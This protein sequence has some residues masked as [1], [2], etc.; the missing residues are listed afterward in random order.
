VSIQRLCLAAGRKALTLKSGVE[1]VKSLGDFAV[2]FQEP[3]IVR[4]DDWLQVFDIWERERHKE[5]RELGG[6]PM[7]NGV[8][9]KVD[10][11]LR[12]EKTEGARVQDVGGPI[13]CEKSFAVRS[14]TLPVILSI[15]FE[16]A[17]SRSSPQSGGSVPK[18]WLQDLPRNLG[19][20]WGLGDS[21]RPNSTH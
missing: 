3:R 20:T 12:S 17:D 14:D 9:G 19:S 10:R 1:V 11:H 4:C 5:C 6:C 16:T 18:R 8:A 13:T 7:E 2:G 15:P 21:I